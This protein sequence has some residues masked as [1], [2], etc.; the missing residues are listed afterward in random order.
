MDYFPEVREFKVENFR[1]IVE[2]NKKAPLKFRTMKV[3]GMGIKPEVFSAS[4]LPSVD[5]QALKLLAGNPPKN[6]FG[7]AFDH[8]K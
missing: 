7:S 8:F 6:Q 4:G 1:G 5:I 3:K 2:E